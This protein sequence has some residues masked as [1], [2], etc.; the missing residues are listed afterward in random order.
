MPCQ[1]SAWL[2]LKSW[3]CT[4]SIQV[5][6]ARELLV[7]W[8]S[9]KGKQFCQGRIYYIRM[10]EVLWYLGMLGYSVLASNGLMAVTSGHGACVCNTL[11]GLKSTLRGKGHL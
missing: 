9:Q 7:R 6:R 3:G 5:N 2:L 8:G 1:R 10:P 11:A 4:G